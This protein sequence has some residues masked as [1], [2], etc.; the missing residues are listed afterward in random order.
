MKNNIFINLTKKGDVLDFD[1]KFQK[2]TYDQF[3]EDASE[4]T[5][6]EMFVSI[7][8]DKGT[9][10]QLA[11][12]HVMIRELANTLGYTFEEAKLLMKRKAGLCVVKNKTEY[13]KSFGDC[14]KEELNLVIQALI[15]VGDFTNTN[16]R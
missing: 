14:D 8:T 6:V 3:I 16:L 4:G 2:R 11:R 10:A 1:S 9:N 5:K 12:V 7:S 13:C 15:E